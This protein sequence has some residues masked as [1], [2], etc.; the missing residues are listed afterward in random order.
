[1]QQTTESNIQYFEPLAPETIP[2]FEQ[3]GWAIP[4]LISFKNCAYTSA[5]EEVQRGS[6]GT[7]AWEARM[8]SCDLRSVRDRDGVWHHPRPTYA[9]V[10]AQDALNECGTIRPEPMPGFEQMGWAIPSIVSFKDCAYT[11]APK[12]AQSKMEGIVAWEVTTTNFDNP[13]VRDRDG[14]WHNPRPTYVKNLPERTNDA[15]PHLARI[16]VECCGRCEGSDRC[17]R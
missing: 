14:V 16:N 6:E 4:R 11:S 5:P 13:A 15:T 1:M 2:G 9:R 8:R 10:A 3:I 7:V 17:E 12:D